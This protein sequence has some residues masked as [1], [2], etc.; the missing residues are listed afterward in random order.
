M[1]IYKITNLLN[2]KLYIGKT[3]KTIKQRFK[4]HIMDAFSQKHPRNT[5][6]CNALRK[7]GVENFKI[8]EVCKC[9]TKEELNEREIY[10]IKYYNT[11]DDGYNISKGGDGGWTSYHTNKAQKELMKWRKGKTYEEI[12]GKDKA[13]KIKKLISDGEKGKFVSDDTKEKIRKNSI[14]WWKD[15]YEKGCE[16]NKQI[17]KKGCEHHM[18]GH[19]HT[20]EARKKI[21]L[22][23]KNKTYEEIYGLDEALKMKEKRKIRMM[24]SKNPSFK[25]IDMI[26]VFE[27]LIENPYMKL[28]IISSM[29]GVSRNTLSRKIKKQLNIKNIQ[30][31]R[32]KESEDLK[33]IFKETKDKLE[34]GKNN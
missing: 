24:D 10:Y 19:T 6:I 20:L 13:E 27:L 1:Y 5:K 18:Y 23:K 26:K 25:D 4:K 29:M 33:K 8:E 30:I 7:Y 17:A 14:Q 31:F 34:N 22:S 15:N 11:I 3:T 12:Y 2:N 28:D 9:E 16:T 32:M 21:S